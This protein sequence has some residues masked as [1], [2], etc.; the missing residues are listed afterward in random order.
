MASIKLSEMRGLRKMD[1]G[2]MHALVL[3]MLGFAESDLA[4]PETD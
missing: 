2:K 4:E 3:T 1:A